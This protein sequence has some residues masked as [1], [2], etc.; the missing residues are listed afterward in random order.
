MANNLSFDE[1]HQR[2][3]YQCLDGLR[4][5][6]VVLVMWHHG[7]LHSGGIVF[8]RGFLGVEMF[9]VLSGFLIVSLLLRERRELGAISLRRF[10][11]RRALRILPPF[12]GLLALLALGHAATR[13]SYSAAFFQQLP[14]QVGHLANWVRGDVLGL[15]MSWTLATEEQFYLVIP[16]LVVVVP[17]RFL[18]WCLGVLGAFSALLWTSVPGPLLKSIYGTSHPNLV[19]LEATYMSL[20]LGALMACA[21]ESKRTFELLAN[22]AKHRSLRTFITVAMVAVAAFSPLVGGG[23]WRF[24]FQ[25]LSAGWIAG[26]VLQPSRLASWFFE[27]RAT[28]RLG[29][30]SYGLYLYH[31]VCFGPAFKISARLGATSRWVGFAI[32]CLVT[33]LVASASYRFFE[34]PIA[35]YAARFKPENATRRQV[36]GTVHSPTA[37]TD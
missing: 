17:R 14:F 10:Y 19:F 3:H 12:Y 22:V 30:I 35:R 13:N 26:L 28:R 31:L 29:T 23:P 4:G 5:L 24:A 36:A 6:A 25:V 20:I 27:H 7:R 9:F 1:F 34:Q 2:R 11:A 18:G 8:G 15:T 37:A 16:F 21:F 32:G 33:Y